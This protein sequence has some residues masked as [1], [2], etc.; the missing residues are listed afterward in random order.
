VHRMSIQ[1]HG[2]LFG[3]FR[4]RQQLLRHFQHDHG[5]RHTCTRQKWAPTKQ[6]QKIKKKQ[7]HCSATMTHVATWSVFQTKPLTKKKQT[8]PDEYKCKR[9]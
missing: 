7:P 6:Q 5:L 2:H 8:V 1:M 3:L 9:P 4:H